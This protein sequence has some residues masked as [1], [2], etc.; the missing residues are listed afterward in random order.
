ML[1]CPWDVA[2]FFIFSSNVPNILYYA[3]IPG[4]FISIF[5]SSF[6]L[7]KNKK[8]LATKLLFSMSLLFAIWGIFALILFATNNPREV[9]IFWSLTILVEVMMYATGLYLTYVFIDQ[10]DISFT[11]KIIILCILLPR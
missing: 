5:L 1:Y 10:K 7:F 2:K 9:M 8:S 6:V 11:K 3:L 4:I